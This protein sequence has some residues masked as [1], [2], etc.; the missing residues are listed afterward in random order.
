MRILSPRTDLSPH[1]QNPKVL[2]AQD[3]HYWFGIM[4][5][6]AWCFAEVI[7]YSFYGLNSIDA[8]LVPKPLLFLRYSAFLLLYPIGVS[9]EILCAYST[10][11][12]LAAGKC[13]S[14]GGYLT[15]CPSNLLTYLY[16]FLLMYIPGLPF[17]YM[18]MLGERKKRLYPKPV[19]KLAGIVFPITKKGDRST[20]TTVEISHPPFLPP[21]LLLCARACVRLCMCMCVCVR[22]RM[23]VCTCT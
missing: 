20:T 15:T 2:F 1:A 6:T 5:M 10:E 23:H 9:G 13:P 7:R 19:P 11:P 3:I 16:V 8:K 12:L 17:L 18:A 22:R 21:S 4:T 14:L